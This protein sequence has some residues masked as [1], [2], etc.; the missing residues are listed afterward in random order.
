[1]RTFIMILLALVAVC[2][3]TDDA[4]FMEKKEHFLEEQDEDPEISQFGLILNSQVKKAIRDIVQ[5]MPCG[6]PEYGIPPLAPYTNGDLKLDLKRSPIDSILQFIRFRFDGLNGMEVKKLNIKYTFKKKVQFHFNFRQ[7]RAIAKTFTTDTMADLLKQF[8][9][10]V[11]YEA[12]GPLDFALDNLSFE[13]HFKYKMPFFF[14]S[15]EIYKFVCIVRLGGVHSS[16]GGVMGNGSVNTLINDQIESIIPAVINGYQKEISDAIER[17]FVPRVNA[18]LKGKKIWDV[19]GKAGW[20]P[21]VCD[22]DPAP[23]GLV[24]ED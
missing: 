19:I 15:I 18:A 11:R 5:H 20:N 13:G 17:N 3:A 2:A 16:I 6:W 8:G 10:A 7:L 24:E 1:M 4:S 14:G 23:W 9:I 12:S 21:G 22:P